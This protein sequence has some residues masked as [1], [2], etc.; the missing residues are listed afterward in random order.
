MA[1]DTAV[2]HETSEGAS[3]RRRRLRNEFLRRTVRYA[4]MTARDCQIIKKNTLQCCVAYHEAHP[5]AGSAVSNALRLEMEIHL[6]D[7]IQAL[8]AALHAELEM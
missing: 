1:L 6:L 3:I 2:F 5:G 7:C 8:L 4:L